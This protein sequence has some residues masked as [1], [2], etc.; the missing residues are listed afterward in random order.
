MLKTIQ[1]D[2]SRIENL[3]CDVYKKIED[4]KQNLIG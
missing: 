4:T 3:L 1:F 2:N